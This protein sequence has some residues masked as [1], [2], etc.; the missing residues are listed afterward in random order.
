[1]LTPMGDF[2]QLWDQF[3]PRASSLAYMSGCRGEGAM[4]IRS[5]AW[6][7]WQPVSR[8]PT[9]KKARSHS[10][11]GVQCCCAV[12]TNCPPKRTR[13]TMPKLDLR[14][15]LPLLCSASLMVNLSGCG[16]RHRATR[17]GFVDSSPFLRRLPRAYSQAL[18]WRAVTLYH[19]DFNNFPDILPIT[20]I[21]RGFTRFCIRGRRR[22]GIRSL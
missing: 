18:G 14:G 6:I 7:V 4:S 19:S 1:M 12:N 13:R 10:D 3:Q 11:C 21:Q 15:W 22:G 9:E 8:D 2:T 20:A 16:P 5:T 17:P